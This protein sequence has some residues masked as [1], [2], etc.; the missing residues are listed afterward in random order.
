MTEV[1]LSNADGSKKIV[2]PGH[3]F[4]KPAMI[5]NVTG[6]VNDEGSNTGDI[7]RQ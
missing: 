4:T 1:T 6:D 7:T 2:S 3:G 5:G